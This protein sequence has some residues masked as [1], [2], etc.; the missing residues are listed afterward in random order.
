MFIYRLIVGVIAYAAALLAIIPIGLLTV[1]IL[2]EERSLRRELK[3]YDAY[4][5]RARWRLIPLF[6]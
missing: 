5:G 2:F 3:G 1:R 6:W 4:M